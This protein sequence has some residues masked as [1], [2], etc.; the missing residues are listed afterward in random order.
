MIFQCGQ[1]VEWKK[2]ISMTS[3]RSLTGCSTLKY[4]LILTKL[5]SI[6]FI[7]LCCWYDLYKYKIGRLVC[8][9]SIFMMIKMLKIPDF[10]KIIKYWE[11]KLRVVFWVS[12]QLDMSSSDAVRNIGQCC[13]YCWLRNGY[14]VNE[15]ITYTVELKGA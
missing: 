1:P 4:W 11:I 13:L 10:K 14:N 9:W 5:G 8:R 2:G 12:Q 7:T 6:M 15:C 3:Y